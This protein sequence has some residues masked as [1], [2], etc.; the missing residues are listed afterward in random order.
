MKL[1]AEAEKLYLSLVHEGMPADG[2]AMCLEI[3]RMKQRLDSL[4]AILA[5]DGDIFHSVMNDEGEIVLKV[6]SALQESRQLATV[7]RQSIE[8]VKRRWPE[9]SGFDEEDILNDL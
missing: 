8:S 1:T 2:L 4:D 3:A 9:E 6:D 7:F 5:G